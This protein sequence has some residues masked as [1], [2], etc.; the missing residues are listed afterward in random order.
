METD[1]GEY[2]AT[3]RLLMLWLPSVEECILDRFHVV[4]RVNEV[5]NPHN[6]HFYELMIVKQREVV[7]SRDGHLER[8]IDA[9]LRAGT[10][11]KEVTFRSVKYVWGGAPMTQ[12]EIDAHKRSGVYHAMLSSTGA[13]VPVLPN[14]RQHVDDFYPLWQA[15]VSEAIRRCSLATALLLATA[16]AGDAQAI[17]I[18]AAGHHVH[19]WLD[20]AP[21]AVV[22]EVPLRSL[23]CADGVV[24][25]LFI[26][27]K[28]EELLALRLLT[29]NPEEGA[30]VEALSLSIACSI[31]STGG[32]GCTGKLSVAV[33]CGAVSTSTSA[34]ALVP[35]KAVEVPDA[36]GQVLCDWIEFERRTRLGLKRFRL[37]SLEKLTI[38]PFRETVRDANGEMQHESLI[39]TAS[40][41]HTHRR[42]AEFSGRGRGE[43]LATGS[44]IEGDY[45]DSRRAAIRHNLPGCGADVPHDETQVAA[46]ANKL[47]G[48]DGMGNATGNATTLL[49]QRPFDYNLPRAASPHLVLVKQLKGGNAFNHRKPARGCAMTEPDGLPALQL[50]SIISVGTGVPQASRPTASVRLLLEAHSVATA[51]ALTASTSRKRKAV[52]WTPLPGCDCGSSAAHAK[53]VRKCARWACTCKPASE[54]RGGDYTHHDACVRRRYAHHVLSF[55]APRQGDRV[56]MIHEARRCGCP[57]LVHDGS[58]W[59][60][61]PQGRSVTQSAW[62]AALGS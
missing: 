62:V 47:A 26:N 48:F 13:L 56:A 9:R 21:H 1:N 53:H 58:G 18:I 59:V 52:E 37:C 40:N 45:I 49:P 29:G 7:T 4:H 34:T 3:T 16:T 10:L 23:P 41:E 12:P 11:R 61:D 2:D 14:P 44:M 38:R 20:A 33:S 43:D 60:A 51:A 30:D 54:A 28:G 8:L 32:D 31:S 22:C 39:A 19:S 15:E 55:A 27:S 46:L 25:L 57:D 42:L 24:Q 6:S 17:E 36:K 35:V 50:R 5:F